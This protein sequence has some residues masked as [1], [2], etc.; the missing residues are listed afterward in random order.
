IRHVAPTPTGELWW[1]EGVTLY[2]ADLVLR[3]AG[4]SRH[5]ATREDHLAALI[6]TYLANPSHARVPPDH[7]SRAFNLLGATG[8]YTPSMF[9]QGEILA[10]LLD[11]MIRSA[12]GGRRSLDDV[13]RALTQR[14]TSER[15]LAGSDVGR[16]VAA[17]CAC[18]AGPFFDTYVRSAAPLDFD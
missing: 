16:A 10:N 18:D 17:A 2:F 3:R 8:D 13:M 11:L 14:F 12:S 9:T 15:G 4:F 1:S 5:D 7:T 6:R